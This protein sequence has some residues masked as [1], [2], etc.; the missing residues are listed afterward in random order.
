MVT[1]QVKE[2]LEL[3]Q[4]LVPD[5]SCTIVSAIAGLGADPFT[6]T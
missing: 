6:E 1:V 4:P 5:E 2:P 3:L